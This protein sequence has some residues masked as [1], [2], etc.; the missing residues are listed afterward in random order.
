MAVGQVINNL[1]VVI[2]GN[3][4]RIDCKVS[5][6][7]SLELLFIGGLIVLLLLRM[8]EKDLAFL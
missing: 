7:R 5:G 4:I 3:G 6:P 1:L 8:H 2:V